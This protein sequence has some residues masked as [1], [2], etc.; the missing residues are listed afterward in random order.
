MRL[1]EPVQ[2]SWKAHLALDFASRDG[3]SLLARKDA[4]GPLVVQKPLYPEGPE[5]CHAIVVHP[6]GGVVGGDELVLEASLASGAA[7]LLTTPGAGKWYRSAGPCARQQLAFA[8]EGGLEWLPRETIVFD[9]ALAGL[10]CRIRLG[11]HARYIG[12]DV[13]CL[14]RT[15]SGER[16]A[17]GK[18]KIDTALH[19]DDRL[20]W[21]ERGEIEGGGALMRSPA[22]LGGHSVFGTLVA[23][24]VPPGLLSTCRQ[25][26]AATLLPGLLIARYLGDS[27]EEALR[28]FTRIWQAIRPSVMGR[29]AVLPRIWST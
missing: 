3:R 4:D 24:D 23:T 8:V 20:V 27:T 6:P 18:L 9:G 17:K 13:V 28:A 7:A 29:E 15:G 1:A 16:F 19:R 25:F 2:A 26:A 12:W 10:E 5:V 22:G 21:L 11:A 14:G